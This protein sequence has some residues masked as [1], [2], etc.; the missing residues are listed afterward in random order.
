MVS[1]P[2]DNPDQVH[3]GTVEGDYMT[4]DGFELVG[5]RRRKE[6]R[7]AANSP[8]RSRSPKS[9]RS[10]PAV[11]YNVD[12][13]LARAAKGEPAMPGSNKFI[14]VISIDDVLHEDSASYCPSL[15]EGSDAG[16]KRSGKL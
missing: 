7:A 12:Q 11:N 1:S 3:N 9:P 6:K 16:N 15:S 14:G 5:P 10:V 4:Q 8:P 2:G 13:A